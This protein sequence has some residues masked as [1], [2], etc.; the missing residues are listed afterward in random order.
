MN[1]LC[2]PPPNIPLRESLGLQPRD[3]VL[4]EGPNRK[5]FRCSVRVRRYEK[6][7][8]AT[9][10]NRIMKGCP[11]GARDARSI[12]YQVDLFLSRQYAALNN[13]EAELR[14]NLNYLRFVHKISV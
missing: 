5:Q 4:V 12:S 14:E 2:A 6:N 7:V 1:E 3:T 11:E 8:L 9:R 10:K 13:C